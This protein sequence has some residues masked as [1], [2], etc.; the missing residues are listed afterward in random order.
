MT[1][2]KLIA[3]EAEDLEIVS[4]HVQDAVL[5]VKDLVFLPKER[6]FALAM[7]RFDWDHNG[8]GSRQRRQAVL[9]FERVE[10]VRHKRI[11]R[12]A[13]DA[14]LNLLA[15]TFKPTDAPAGTISLVFSGNGE[16]QLDVECIE[17]RLSDLG[18]A[19]KTA[20]TPSH[21]DHAGDGGLTAR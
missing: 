3:L 16:I 10:M 19:W 7:N 1:P 2:L 21:A 4:A 5:K 8:G 17:A 13:P 14:V 9:H 15:V 20:R 11:R 6:R 12:D 18:S